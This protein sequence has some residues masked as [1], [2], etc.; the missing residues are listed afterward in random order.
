MSCLH[1]CLSGEKLKVKKCYMQVNKELF[2]ENPEFL[3]PAAPTLPGKLAVVA[4]AMPELVAAAAAKA[5]S[6]WGRLAGE[7]THHVFAT[8]TSA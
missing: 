4:N 7:I 5:I 8:S 6:E 3:D 2:R 1:A